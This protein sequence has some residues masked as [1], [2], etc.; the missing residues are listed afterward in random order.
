MKVI[1][2][3]KYNIRFFGLERLHPFDSQK[4]GRAWKSLRKQFGSQLDQAW[5]KPTRCTNRDE[6]LSVHWEGHL[7]NLRSSTYVAKALEVP[8]VKHLPWQVV[9]SCVLR[10]MLWATHGTYLAAKAALDEPD[11]QAV[12]LGGGFHHAKPRSGEGFCVF[13]DIGIAIWQLRK[14]GKLSEKGRIAYV[15]LDAHQGNGVAYVFENDPSVLIF[16]MYNADI[17]PYGDT[18]A[19]DRVDCGIKLSCGTRGDTYLNELQTQ[20]PKFLDS[21]STTEPVELVIYNAG[22]DI[23][24]GDPLGAMNVSDEAILKRDRFVFDEAVKRKIPVVMLLSG[25]Y[26]RESYQLV[27]NSVEILLHQSLANAAEV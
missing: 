27:A 8:P 25:G 19:T 2:S 4:Y 9:H 20:L 15:D 3:K 12:N 24:A 17:Y 16:D 23:Y 1:Y 10:P 22:T 6:L 5:L 13:S 14:E 18:L 26:T 7:S 21:I 11:H